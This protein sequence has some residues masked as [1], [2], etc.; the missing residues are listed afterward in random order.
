MCGICGLFDTAGHG[1]ADER[2]L[3][4][5]NGKLFHRGPDGEGYLLDGPVGLAMRR[6]SIIDLPGG[7]QPVFN[8]DKTLAV[9]FNGEIYNHRALAAGLKAKRHVFSTACDTETL[10]HL[11]EEYGEDMFSRLRGMFAFA[12]WDS[13]RKRMLVARDRLGKKPLCYSFKNGRLAFASEMEALLES[14]VASREVDF[15]ALDLYLGL[16]YIPAPLSIFKDVRKL[17]PG[18]FISAQAGS[19]EIKKYW[20]LRPA[21]NSLSGGYDDAVD[22][23]RSKLEESVK[24]RLEAD[25]P[26]GAFLSGGV[27]SS[28]VVAFMA[29]NSSAPVKTFSIGFEGETASEL[30]FARET[31]K[32][33][34]TEHTEITVR[35]DMLSVLPMLARHYGEPFADSSAVPSYYVARETAKHVKVALNGDGGDEAFC[36]YP[37][38]ATL[39]ARAGLLALPAMLR[40]S[41]ASV[42]ACLPQGKAKRFGLSLDRTLSELHFNAISYFGAAEKRRLYSKETAAL[43]DGNMR[44]AEDYI[45]ALFTRAAC[46]GA[47]AQ[48]SYCDYNSYLPHCLLA[49]MDIASM[50][51]SLE[52]RSPFL[53]HELVE[54]AFAL[55]AEYKTGGGTGKRI[56]KDALRGIVP[57]SVLARPKTGFALPLDSWL[58]GELKDFWTA[59]VLS[60]GARRRGWFDAGYVK[61]LQEAHL[62][63]QADNGRLLWSLMMLELWAAEYNI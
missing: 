42:A 9:V 51:A 21:G 37:R 34:S 2:A 61:S 1:G 53:D 15:T 49:K 5:M 30:P 4:A 10:V 20:E 16:Q 11:Y 39:S 45:G 41:V 25:V 26:L 23:V 46:A 6:L 14:G 17:E 22:L 57:D 44:G 56:L 12:L 58:R 24:Q 27:D 29:R 3:R 8:E 13:R 52:A 55:P 50:A 35:P 43:L 59:T 38:Y 36:G 28:A 33:Y 18:C 7:G 31:A 62:S 48:M 40:K 47:L 54:L 63:G 32:R 60:D 19:C